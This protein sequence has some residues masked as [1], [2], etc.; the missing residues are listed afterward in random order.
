MLFE[1]LLETLKEREC[2]RGSS[3]K[4]GEELIVVERTHLAGAMLHDGVAEADLSV[5][6]D[7]SL[8]ALANGQN[9]RGMRYD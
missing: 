4:T 1:F 3:G 2:I 9:C 6:G 5:A 7:T 8:A